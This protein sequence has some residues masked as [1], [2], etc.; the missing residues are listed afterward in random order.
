MKRGPDERDDSDEEL[1]NVWLL[2][3]Q[4]IVVVRPPA[5]APEPAP[6]PEPAGLYQVGAVTDSTIVLVITVSAKAVALIRKSPLLQLFN[7]VRPYA[8][9]GTP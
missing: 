6:T 7:E 1:G 2:S 8:F 4:V 5:P 3:S 9:L